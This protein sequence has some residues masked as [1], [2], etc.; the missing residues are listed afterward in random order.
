MREAADSRSAMALSYLCLPSGR[1]C[2]KTLKAMVAEAA[3]ES[4]KPASSS[5]QTHAD[6][7]ISSLLCN[8]VAAYWG[9]GQSN[10]SHSDLPHLQAEPV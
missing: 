3:E 7:C 5:S 8:W 9:S 6:N 1:D 4:P 10:V 2:P